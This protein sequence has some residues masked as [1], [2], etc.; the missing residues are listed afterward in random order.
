MMIARILF[1]WFAVLLISPRGASAAQTA[2]TTRPTIFICGDSTAKNTAKGKNGEALAGWGT[3]I[4]DYF[5]SAKVQIANVAHAGRSSETYYN[6]DWP[7]VL[8]RITPG[9]YML[10]VFGINDGTTLSGT[11]DETRTGRDGQLEHT[12]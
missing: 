4:A 10:L 12:Y 6:G 5:D 8:P 7:N 1:V 9:D 11:G 3:P 2:T